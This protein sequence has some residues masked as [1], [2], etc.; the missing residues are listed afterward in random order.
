M[1]SGSNPRFQGLSGTLEGLVIYELNGQTVMRGKPGPRTTQTAGERKNRSQFCA[2]AHAWT[3]DVPGSAKVQWKKM[4]A[5]VPRWNEDGSPSPAPLTGHQCFVQVNRARQSLSLPLLLDCPG[6]P[7]LPPFLGDVRVSAVAGSHF[8]L[9]LT[10]DAPFPFPCQVWAAPAVLLSA[11]APPSRRFTQILV[12]PMGL[13]AQ[14]VD[15]GAA[16]LQ[17]IGQAW[18]DE[19]ICLRLLPLSPTGFKGQMVAVSGDVTGGV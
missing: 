14:G 17:H 10:P 2:V 12:L 6:V 11:P 13:P 18:P 16:F 4:A 1:A 9:R 19:K 5:R 3:N 7:D 8:S 15:A